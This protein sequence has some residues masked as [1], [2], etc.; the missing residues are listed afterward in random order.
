MIDYALILFSIIFTGC[1]PMQTPYPMKKTALFFI[2]FTTA[3]CASGQNRNYTATN[4]TVTSV[5]F[6][7][8]TVDVLAND[9]YPPGD[10]VE[11]YNFTRVDGFWTITETL[12]HKLV[13]TNNMVNYPDTLSIYYAF[14]NKSDSLQVSNL[15][16]LLVYAGVNTDSIQ[17]ITDT[18]IIPHVIN[19]SVVDL[20]LND[21][22]PNP[23]DTLK[24][25]NVHLNAPYGTIE[26][27]YTAGVP[28]IIAPT[29]YTLPGTYS[30]TYRLLRKQTCGGAPYALGRIVLTVKSNPTFGYLDTNNINARINCYGNHFCDFSFYDLGAEFE[31]PKGGGKGTIFNS[32]IWIGGYDEYSQLCLAGGEYRTGGA[33]IAG[34]SPD[35]YCGPVMDLLQYNHT[36]DSLW[37]RIWKISRNEIEYHINH[38]WEQGYTPP[39]AILNWPAKGD[40][41]LGE[42]ENLAPYFDR[43]GDGDYNALDGDYP[44]IRGDMAIFFIFNDDRDIHRDTQGRKMKVEIHGMAYAFNCPGDTAF[45]NTVF[46]HYDL[47]NRSQ[48]T[49][50]D[51]YLG[52]FTD[53]DIGYM[54]DDYSGCDVERSSYFGYNGYP[55]DGTGQP[56]AYGA[57]PPAQAVTILAGPFLDPDGL[58]D[59]RFDNLGNQ[60]CNP[61]VN[62]HH[63]G[64]AIVDNERYGMTGYMDLTENSG[65]PSFG[66]PPYARDYYN[67]MKCYWTETTPLQYGGMGFPNSGAYGPACKFMFPG[68][69]DTL[70][71]GVG[72]TAP[73]GPKEWTCESVNRIPEDVKGVGNTGPFTF[74]PG[75]K[76]ELDLAYIFAQSPLGNNIAS[77]T[78]LRGR[79]SHILGFYENDSVPGGKTFTSVEQTSGSSERP[80]RVWPNPA[81]NYIN[82]EFTAS[83]KN[84]SYGIMNLYGATII[85]GKLSPDQS[86]HKIGLNLPQGMYLLVI[87]DNSKSY[88][89]KVII[90]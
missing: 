78:E 89:R 34:S 52:V 50:S 47:F 70:D 83:D 54:N 58:D 36:Q 62:G 16:C 74:K 68:N 69:S 65:I 61:S 75:D 85:Q 4:D 32:A 64:D 55:V 45:N 19:Q 71:W 66:E 73:N 43:N 53:F 21:I 37:N 39:E 40:T 15:A 38:W 63:F 56:Y 46:L 84:C 9:I 33:A 17:A 20:T 80:L 2:L 86:Y 87:R 3:L 31:A 10:E 77:L 11:F 49:F 30:G 76:Q 42:A 24:I 13:L 26:V 72:C 51:T 23:G 44:I 25:S 29:L 6:R 5:C 12:D 35:F 7:N 48:M 14:R 79:I 8:D 27:R 41:T 28:V 82:V 57:F 1:I 67:W 90:R 88:T 60:L 81:G 22:N 18:I 59:P